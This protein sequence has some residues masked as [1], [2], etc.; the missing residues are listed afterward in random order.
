LARTKAALLLLALCLLQ[1]VQQVLPADPRGLL[2][3]VALLA[4]PLSAELDPRYPGWPM[5]LLGAATSALAL[6][7]LAMINP[8]RWCEASIAA[9]CVVVGCALFRVLKAR[10]VLLVLGVGIG[11]PL[12]F[13]LLLCVVS[14]GARLLLPASL[15]E[16][17]PSFAML[18]S[19]GKT[20]GRPRDRSS[21]DEI[22]RSERGPRP[23]ASRCSRAQL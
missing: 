22:A 2:G 19:N 6:V 20:A 13:G 17:H 8:E 12:L 9:A 3:A 21:P 5:R 14:P 23:R 18:P 7:A 1:Q 10:E 11:A 16:W 15:G 4:V